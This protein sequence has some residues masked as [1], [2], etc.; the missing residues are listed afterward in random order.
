ME[1]RHANELHVQREEYKRTPG[2]G[3]NDTLQPSSIFSHIDAP[4]HCVSRGL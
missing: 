3:T 1:V 4:N 2:D